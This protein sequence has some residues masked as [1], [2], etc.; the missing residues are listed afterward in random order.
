[1]P[2]H[3]KMC[4]VRAM[5]DDGKCANEAENWERSTLAFYIE[6]SS[7]LWWAWGMRRNQEKEAKKKCCINTYQL[8]RYTHFL[9]RLQ[10]LFFSAAAVIKT[11]L[12]TERGSR[13]DRWLAAKCALS[14]SADVNNHSMRSTHLKET[15]DA[16]QLVHHN[17]LSL[18]GRCCS[19]IFLA[20]SCFTSWS[21]LRAE[22]VTNST[23][24]KHLSNYL[25]DHNCHRLLRPQ[26]SLLFYRY[27]VQP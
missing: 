2:F 26:T 27:F 17:C 12:S 15:S 13:V 24:Q 4:T 9:S 21:I 1:M 25:S 6:L 22:I 8:C 20:L 5:C 7:L 14:R 3:C 23:H 18:L 10:S 19:W 11:L 16:V